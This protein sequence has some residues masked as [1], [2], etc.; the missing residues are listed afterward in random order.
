MI[1]IKNIIRVLGILLLTSGWLLYFYKTKPTFYNIIKKICVFIKRNWRSIVWLVIYIILLF[2]SST[3]VYLNWSRCLNIEFFKHFNG[4]NIIWVL[5][6]FLLF[7]PLISVDNQ[8]FK[9]PNPLS[10]R[11]KE[12]SEAKEAAKLEKNINVLQ[13]LSIKNLSEQ[14]DEKQWN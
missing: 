1:I 10:K 14:G 8:W 2:L 5:W 3:F 4:Y 11:E 13:E 7:I 12:I 9:I 6:L